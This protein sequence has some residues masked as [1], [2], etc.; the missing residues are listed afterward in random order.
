MHTM[1]HR[2]REPHPSLKYFMEIDLSDLVIHPQRVTVAIHH[3]LLTTPQGILRELYTADIAGFRLQAGNVHNIQRLVQKFIPALVSYARLPDYVF[4]GRRSGHIYPVYT[5]GDDV[6]AATPGGPTFRH[7]ELAKVRAYLMDY[8]VTT[9][10]LAPPGQGEKLHV[11]G[12]SRS[13]LALLRP[14]FY[15]KKRVP[16]QTEFWAPVFEAEDGRSIYAYV[17]SAKREVPIEGGSEV[18]ALW[19]ICAAALIAD[20]RL[21]ESYDL[22]PD[23]LM[24]HYWA[25]LEATLEPERYRLVVSN[26][27][28]PGSSIQLPLYRNDRFVVAL[29]VRSAENRFGLFIGRS[30]EDVRERVARDLV[31]RSLIDSPESVRIAPLRHENRTSMLDSLLR[32]PDTIRSTEYAIRS[33]EYAIRST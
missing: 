20:R 3:H 10:E 15:L 16:G 30:V 23:R 25:R 21:Q 24:P 5:V 13:T 18:L 14:V 19:D 17:A 32:T 29:E 33:T 1:L 11:R 7:V 22:R 28:A 6:I 31:R 27:H 2:N 8:L 4:I 26:H 9:G 12:V